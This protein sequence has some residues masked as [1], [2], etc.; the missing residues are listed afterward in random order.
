MTGIGFTLEPHPGTGAAPPVRVTGGIRRHFDVLFVHFQLDGRV[1]EVRI[2]PPSKTPVR[3][4]RLWEETCFEF[5]IGPKGS[6]RYWEFNA[7]PAGDWNAYRFSK[8]RESM[9]EEGSIHSL[10]TRLERGVDILLFS[11]ECDLKSLLPQVQGVEAG[12]SAVI[13]TDA[14]EVFYFALTHPG[15]RPDF[16]RRDGFLIE[17]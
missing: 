14:E 8:Y 1:E 9:Q 11:V 16:H 4:D 13:K 7:S 12:V 5:F 6:E 3:R 15:T 10:P 17:L 2:P